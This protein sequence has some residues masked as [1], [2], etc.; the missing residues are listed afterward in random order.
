VAEQSD[1]QLHLAGLVATPFG[2]WIDGY[3][4][5]YPGLKE[6]V[7]LH[8]ELGRQ[9]LYRLYCRSSIFCMSSR[10]EGMAIVFPEAMYYGNAIVTTWPVSVKELVEKN[11]LG[12][13]V[14]KDD[15]DALSGALL[16][17]I[18]DDTL[19]QGMA[20]R[21]FEVAN[22]LL[23]WDK[24]IRSLDSEIKTRIDFEKNKSQDSSN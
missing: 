15:R 11:N 5:D 2:K 23:N 16:T 20:E 19:R 4:N 9:E 18:G 7:I 22:S 13:T 24:I 17:L 21:A 6:R 3:F 10:Y 14:E 8:G 12:I 1:F